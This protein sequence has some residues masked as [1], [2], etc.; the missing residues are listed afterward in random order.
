MNR[1]YPPAEPLPRPGPGRSRA[2]LSPAEE[3][4]ILARVAGLVVTALAL[5]TFGLLASGCG[6]PWN[7]QAHAAINAQAKLL[8]ASD[9]ALERQID[10]DPEQDGLV[11][12]ERYFNVVLATRAARMHLV[13][14]E[15]VVDDAERVQSTPEQCRALR[16]VRET[17][18]E[19][20][21]LML[22]LSSLGVPLPPEATQAAQFAEL[23]APL[24]TSSCEGVQ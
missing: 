23:L 17:V 8:R 9:L 13:R 4:S 6:H 12:H 22:D 18:Q 3:R 5:I 16:V 15:H 14:A 11:I 1:R 7:V 20:G 2:L 21:R 19:V 24:I 10:E